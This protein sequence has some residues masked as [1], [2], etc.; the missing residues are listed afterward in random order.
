[1][2]VTDRDREAAQRFLGEYGWSDTIDEASRTLVDELARARKEGR[3]GMAHE[4]ASIVRNIVHTY[5]TEGQVAFLHEA[6]E[7]AAE[8]ILALVEKPSCQ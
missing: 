1:M 4:A 8:E 5:V 7:K 2:A 3:L 6:H